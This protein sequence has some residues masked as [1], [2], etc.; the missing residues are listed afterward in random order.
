MLCKRYLVYRTLIQ[1][2]RFPYE[3]KIIYF[4]RGISKCGECK[5][6]SQFGLECRLH[7][8]PSGGISVKTFCLQLDRQM[9]V[10]YSL[11]RIIPI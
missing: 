3:P 5:F 4:K 10:K 8:L 6:N 9:T 1:F 2:Y 11:D 7:T